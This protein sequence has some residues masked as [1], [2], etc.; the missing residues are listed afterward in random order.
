M[1]RTLFLRILQAIE[2]HDEYFVQKRNV[3]SILGLSSLQKITTTFRML[4]YGVA[5]D[6]MDDYVRIGEST[7]IKSLRRFVSAVVE[8]FGDEY[9][10]SPNE[11][12]TARLLAIGERRGFPGMLRSID[13]VH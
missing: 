6:A 2:Q 3:A 13:C 5:A 4:A 7:A 8:V 1:G 10:I 9:L 12:D 11:D